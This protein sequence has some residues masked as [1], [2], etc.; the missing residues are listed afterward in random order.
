MRWRKTHTGSIASHDTPERDFRTNGNSNSAPGNVSNKRKS[1][2]SLYTKRSEQAST[3]NGFLQAIQRLQKQFK[4]CASEGG[5]AERHR[6]KVNEDIMTLVL[7]F[8]QTTH[9]KRKAN[10]TIK[11]KPEKQRNYSTTVK[12]TRSLVNPSNS[13]IKSQDFS[14][15]HPRRTNPQDYQ[16]C[17]RCY[18]LWLT[19]E[20]REDI[21]RMPACNVCGRGDWKDEKAVQ[22]YQYGNGDG[23]WRRSPLYRSGSPPPPYCAGETRD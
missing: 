2:R 5:D 1:D 11:Q 14:K 21:E 13:R 15:P 3:M 7:Q 20:M 19:K 23:A 4:G 8:P 10:S 16:D 9:K 18:R 17:P 6:D 12:A 22:T